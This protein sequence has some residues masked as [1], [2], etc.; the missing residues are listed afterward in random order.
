[1]SCIWTT[2]DCERYPAQQK[3]NM[4]IL[5]TWIRPASKKPEDVNR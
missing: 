4:F 3:W 2:G 5:Q 1:M